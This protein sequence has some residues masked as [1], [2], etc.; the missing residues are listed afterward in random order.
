M[1]CGTRLNEAISVV[2]CT[3][4]LW[5]GGRVGRAAFGG[6]QGLRVPALTAAECMDVRLQVLCIKERIFGHNCLR[7]PG[8]SCWLPSGGLARHVAAGKL[9]C[10]HETRSLMAAWQEAKMAPFVAALLSP[11]LH[12]PFGRLGIT[13]G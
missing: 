11:V 2:A 10:T 9:L 6:T 8:V 13:A 4:A 3:H 5:V 12:R 7:A 1:L